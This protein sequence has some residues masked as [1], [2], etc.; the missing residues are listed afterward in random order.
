MSLQRMLAAAWA[1]CAVVLPAMPALAQDNRDTV[2]TTP[3]VEVIGT[4]PLPGIGLPIDEIPA[5]A[6]TVTGTE[7]RNLESINL[8]DFMARAMPSVNVNETTGNPFQSELFYRGFIVSPLLGQPQG[9]SVFQDGVRLNEPF[10]DVVYW[11]LIPQQA[12]AG[13]DLIPGSNP[14]FGLNTLGGALSIRTKDGA[15]FPDSSV[16]VSGGSWGRYTV[17]VEHGGYTDYND[18]Y[19]SASYFDENGWRD[20][21]PSD[22]TQVFAKFGHKDATTALGLGVTYGHSNLT[23]NGVA[24]ESMLEQNRDQVFTIPDNTKKDMYLLNLTG[25]H[26]LNNELQL[27]G[28]AYYRYNHIK[29]LNGDANDDFEGSA[30]DGDTGANGGAGFNQDTAVNNRTDTIE[31]SYGIGLQLSYLLERNQLTV[32]TSV[33]YATSDFKQS[34]AEGI[35]NSR[36]GVD[37]TDDSVLENKLHGTTTTYALYVTDTW[38][39]LP[40]TNLTAS[41]RYNRTT[42]KTEDQLNPNPPNL[43]ADQTYTKLNP[44]IGMTH[45]LLNGPTFFGGWS[46]GS[47]APSP[48]ELG[49]SDPNNPCTLPNAMQSDPPLDQVVTQTWELGARGQLT[50]TINWSVA[51]FRSENHDDI[52]FVST[53]TS[54]GYFD[55]VSKT[56]RQGVELGLNG[57]MG[58]FS[59][60][61]N[62]SYI[63]ATFESNACLVSPNNSSAGQSP[64]CAGA[65]GD[66]IYVKSGD[67]LPGIP[68]N[69]FKLGLDYRA[70]DKFT[71]GMD[72]SVFSS[73]YARGNENNQHESGTFTN[74]I[75]GDTEDFEGSGKAG[76][77]T[78][79]NLTGRY[80]LTSNWQVFARIDNVFNTDY[81]TAAILAENPFN[82]A[83]QFQTNSDDWAHETFFAPGAPR[84]AWIGVRYSI[85]RTPRR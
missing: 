66:E 40:R 11:D 52:L 74:P 62:Y 76:G 22:V 44:A 39:V 50:G 64:N 60:N 9:L 57:T 45:A 33:D 67:K 54:A 1:T 83:G 19:L 70:T 61:A 79:V 14:V 12:I 2:Q 58:R 29:T 51:G 80:Q 20:Y 77:Y 55:N 56:R 3:T 16:E 35:F 8:P 21:S 75:T 42:V 37:Q 81:N 85:D 48:I 15:S 30:N 49:C 24:P 59:W 25:T 31:N 69:Q 38:T 82:S 84:A 36:R 68:E 78:L 4:T 28:N 13:M 5:N 41:A 71:L 32:G 26:L 73:Q 72:V 63:Q 23:G 27:G 7:M 6:Q 10:G 65:N 34:A 53:G 17:G 43:D 47:R 46:Q 18:Y